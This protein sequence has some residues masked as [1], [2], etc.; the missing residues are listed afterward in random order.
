VLSTAKL[1]SLAERDMSY[2]ACPAPELDFQSDR[3]ELW[4][5]MAIARYEGIRELLHF[6][7]EALHDVLTGWS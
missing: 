3:G 5:A 7:Y 1:L 6:G 2:G 4:V